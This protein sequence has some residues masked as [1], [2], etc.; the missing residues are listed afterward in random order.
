MGKMMHIGLGRCDLWGK[1]EVSNP[2]RRC[3][4]CDKIGRTVKPRKEVHLREWRNIELPD[5]L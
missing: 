1:S 5:E 3:N 2:V 4:C